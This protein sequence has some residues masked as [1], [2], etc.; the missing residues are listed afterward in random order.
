MC[1]LL[2]VLAA[3]FHCLLSIH[4]YSDF[5]LLV[6]NQNPSPSLVALEIISIYRMSSHTSATINYAVQQPS[7]GYTDRTTEFD[8][9]LLQRGIVSMEQVLLAKGMSTKDAQYFLQKQKEKEE[10]FE[11]LTTDVTQTT[12]GEAKIDGNSEDDDDSFVDDDDEFLRSY[13]QR[14]LLELQEFAGVAKG[15]LRRTFGDVVLIDRTEWKRHVNEDSMDGTWVVVGL[16]SS[17]D[18]DRTARIEQSINEL[19]RSHVHT[20]FVLIPSHCAIANWPEA[21]LPSL[22]LYKDSTL[23]HELI[24]LPVDMTTEQLEDS[25]VELNVL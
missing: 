20:K 14:R 7:Y 5:R 24:R 16:L 1:K 21:N 2:V 22:F 18:S 17:H 25:L 13:N 10:H 6:E 23:Q 3:R 19:S 11:D 9:A 15:T 12:T 8:D 4:R